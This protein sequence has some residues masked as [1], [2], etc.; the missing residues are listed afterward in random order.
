MGL[1]GM[2]T[3]EFRLGTREPH[4]QPMLLLVSLN[5]ISLASSRYG[6]PVKNTAARRCSVVCRAPALLSGSS[7]AAALRGNVLGP[8]GACARS[9]GSGVCSGA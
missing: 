5:D 3:T 8:P 2:G 4:P 1:G 9:S 7:E 6:F